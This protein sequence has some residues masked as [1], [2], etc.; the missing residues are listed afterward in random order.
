MTSF[1]MR[2]YP[3]RVAGDSGP[4]HSEEI[5]WEILEREGGHSTE[6]REY[7]SVTRKLRRV[8]RFDPQVVREAISVNQ[9]TVIVL[10]HLDYVDSRSTSTQLTP[11]AQRFVEWVEEQIEQDIDYLGLGPD[12]LLQR[13]GLLAHAAA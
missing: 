1:S 8:A 12:S 7:T 13:R 5:S 9:P 3:I 10:N 2:A 4:F 6:I 11:K